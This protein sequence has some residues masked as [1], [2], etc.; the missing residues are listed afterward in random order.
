M[1]KEVGYVIK[2]LR[3]E[4]QLKQQ[5]VAFK[6]GITTEAYA[7]IENGRTDINTNKLSMISLILGTKASVILF[8]AET[9]ITNI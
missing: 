5:Y 1:K 3:K 8:L 6:L 9:Y 7:N 2:K 4:Q